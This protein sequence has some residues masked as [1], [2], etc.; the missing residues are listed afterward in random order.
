[1][2]KGYMDDS[3]SASS[4]LFTLS[5][6]IGHTSMWLWVEWAWLNHLE[7]KNSQL[8]AGGRTEL[9]RFHAADCSSRFGEFKGWTVPEQT[10]FMAGLIRVFQRHSLVIISYTVDLKDLI[11]EFPEAKNNPRGLAH[12]LL[13]THIM[14]YIADKI[15]GDP[16]YADE[17]ISLVHDRSNYDA[18]LRE[19]FDHMR[20]DQTFARRER[21]T[22]ISAKG[23][24]D[25]VP[26]QLADFLAYENFKI[27]ERES[28]GHPRRKSMELILEL[29]SFGGRG[30]K[31]QREGIRQIKSKLHDESKE[32]LFGNARIR[33]PQGK[34]DNRNLP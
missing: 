22:G 5:C 6:L 20:N 3:G 4:N 32:I 15:L 26:L 9:S 11:A 30:A 16:R 2:L 34:K 10:E 21:F 7:K 28:A 1:M 33:L 23:W 14:K 27:I 31:L 29:D 18:V 24:E 19:A 8:K 17:D 13:L 25:C 12:V